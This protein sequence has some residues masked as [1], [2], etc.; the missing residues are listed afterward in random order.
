MNNLSVC[1][2][3]TSPGMELSEAPL[4]IKCLCTKYL[5][6]EAE[7]ALSITSGGIATT[8]KP[9]TSSPSPPRIECPTSGTDPDQAIVLLNFELERADPQI[10]NHGTIVCD[11]LMSTTLNCLWNI[12]F[13]NGWCLPRNINLGDKRKMHRDEGLTEW[14]QKGGCIP[15][16]WQITG[17][18]NRP[19]L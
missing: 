14:L 3:W 13:E 17:L 6:L 10:I 18:S 9:S 15:R 4:V 19:A 2:L 7:S 11:T 5:L 1:L 8:P 12:R 16:S